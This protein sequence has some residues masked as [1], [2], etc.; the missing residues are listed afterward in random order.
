MFEFRKN[1]ISGFPLAT[2]SYYEQGP[3]TM[4]NLG[5][6]ASILAMLKYAGI[7]K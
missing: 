6:A 2:Q 7:L 5:S 1:L 3:S 4:Q